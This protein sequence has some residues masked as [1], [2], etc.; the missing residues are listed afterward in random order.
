ME[1]REFIRAAA[2][3]AVAPFAGGLLCKRGQSLPPNDWCSDIPLQSLSSEDCNKTILYIEWFRCWAKEDGSQATGEIRC[4]VPGGEWRTRKM[5]T[6]LR[7]DGRFELDMDSV[8]PGWI[9]V[10]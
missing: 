2:A 7:D 5:P 4:K 9:L 8:A 6:V 1:R 3:M 10:T